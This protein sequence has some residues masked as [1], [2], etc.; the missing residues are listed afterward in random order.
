MWTELK[1][2]SKGDFIKASFLG[3][4]DPEDEKDKSWHEIYEL[5]KKENG[6]YYT[7]IEGW[8]GAVVSGS[9]DVFRKG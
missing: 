4:R 3:N 9:E 7:A 5:E 1:N 2:C 6:K 8:K